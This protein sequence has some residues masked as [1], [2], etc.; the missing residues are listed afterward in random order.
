MYKISIIFFLLLGTLSLY[1][2]DR[3][4]QVL[5]EENRSSK[6]KFYTHIQDEKGNQSAIPIA[7]I[8]GK[9]KGPTFTLI[10]GVHGFEYPPIIAAQELIQE[11]EPDSLLGTLIIIPISNPNSFYSRTPFLNPKDKL[12]LNRVFPGD[13][14]GS[15]TER[16]ANYITEV[17]IANSDVFVD[18]HGG[19]AN[20]DLLP[21]VCYYDNESK[22]KQTQIIQRLAEGSGF[23]YV[24]SY[25]Y[26]LKDDQPAKY[27]FKQA[28]QDG[29]VALSIES[30]KLGNVQKEAVQQIKKGVYNMLAEMEMYK[31]VAQEKKEFVRLSRQAYIKSN[32]RGVF[33]SKYAAGDKVSQ[34]DIIGYIKNEFG[35]EL[36]EVVSKNSGIILYKIGTPPVNKG[37]TV[38]CVGYNE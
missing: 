5:E 6:Q 10:S 21:F 33:Y 28:V 7:V 18:I 29:K 9:Q 2:Q 26:T 36:E 17:V 31:Q 25:P 13:N 8:K 12:N 38:M 16:I 1:A 30:G 4:Q 32:Y 34:G 24:V 15:I 27:A 35:D 19:D 3:L 14:K 20:E 37:E 23:S 22:P 11:I